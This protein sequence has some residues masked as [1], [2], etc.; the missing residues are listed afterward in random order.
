MRLTDAGIAGLKPDKTEFTVWDRR[1]AGL[2]VR[3]RP[4]GHCSFVWHGHA[5][6]AAVRLTI[7]S[8]ALMT[9][10]DARRECLALQNGSASRIKDPNKGDYARY[11]TFGPGLPIFKAQLVNRMR[12]LVMAAARQARSLAPGARPTR[13]NQLR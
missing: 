1:V 2:G 4:A 5:N 12:H 6:G 9:V 10:E 3:V 8:A 11:L 13:W 7:G